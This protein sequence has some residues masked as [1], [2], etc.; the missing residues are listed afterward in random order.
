MTLHDWIGLIITLAVF[1]LMI[2][3]YWY[4]FHPKNKEKLES[5][6]HIPIDEDRIDTEK[7]DE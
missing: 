3:A 6:R 2:G 4:V 5:Q 1:F 7:N